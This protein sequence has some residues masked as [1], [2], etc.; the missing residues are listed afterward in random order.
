MFM[1]TMG[2]HDVL[3][4]LEQKPMTLWNLKAITD[5]NRN[6][7]RDLLQR[8]LAERRIHVLKWQLNSNRFWVPVYALGDGVDA[9]EPQWTEKQKEMFQARKE[10]AVR[11]YESRRLREQEE[12]REILERRV[13]RIRRDPM[14]EAFFG[15]WKKAA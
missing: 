8:L 9:P 14:V 6:H 4:A 12:E 15:V 7:C 2:E 10:R 3:R 5:M 11:N 13:V 1:S